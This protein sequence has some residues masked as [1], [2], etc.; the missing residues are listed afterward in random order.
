MITKSIFIPI[1][2]YSSVY[3]KD[4]LVYPDRISINGLFKQH[5]RAI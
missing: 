3:L 2:Q 1:N 5:H 4:R